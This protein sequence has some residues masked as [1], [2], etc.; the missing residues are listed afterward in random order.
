[1]LKQC[2]TDKADPDFAELSDELVVIID[3]C[4]YSRIACEEIISDITHRENIVSFE[5]FTDY[6]LWFHSAGKTS[7]KKYIIFN[8]TSEAY[9]SWDVVEFLK[10]FNEVTPPYYYGEVPEYL[11]NNEENVKS[12][13]ITDDLLLLV[14]KRRPQLYMNAIITHY[15]VK[16]NPLA[17][18]VVVSDFS[19][20][21]IEAAKNT[22][23]RYLKRNGAA[24]PMKKNKEYF[25]P[26]DIRAMNILLSGEVIRT[27]SY[28]HAVGVKTL[29]TQRAHVLEKLAF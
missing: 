26:N 17:P 29:Y 4:S 22:F 15:M 19:K 10:H 23:I 18:I 27:A 20:M 14:S 6:K 28:R 21:N 8:A 12:S 2:L 13:N 24:E 25:T 7:G 16:R 9:Y 5:C 3:S 11:K 1:M